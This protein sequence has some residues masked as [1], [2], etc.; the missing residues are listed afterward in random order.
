VVLRNVEVS[1][2]D[3]QLLITLTADGPVTGR[4]Q[5][6]PGPQPRRYVD[7]HGVRPQV[8]AVTP[9]NRGP[10]LRVRVA[11]NMAEPPVTRVVLDMSMSASARI[12][13]GASDNELRIIV[14]EGQ[15]VTTESTARPAAKA[16]ASPRVESAP[17]AEDDLRWCR[18]LADRL[19]GMLETQAPITSQPAMTAAAAAWEQF[20]REFDSR[21]VAQ[22][23]QSIH[24]SLLQATRLGRIATSYRNARQFD[25]ANAALAG[26]RLLLNNA[27]A[28]LAA[29]G[30]Q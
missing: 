3:E 13:R 5:E 9:V 14:G 8:T 23:A 20:E 29:V 18:D 12:E 2:S 25:Q 11:L 27:R 16:P 1:G 30:K 21:K 17:S 6:V 22:A 10:L 24:F 28:Q 26:A 4:L 19:A 7:L 15:S